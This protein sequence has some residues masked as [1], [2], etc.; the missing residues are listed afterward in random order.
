M[1][2]F[3]CANS[4]CSRTDPTGALAAEAP[5][6]FE[7]NSYGMSALCPVCRS[8]GLPDVWDDTDVVLALKRLR[9]FER[10]CDEPDAN[11][12]ALF[13]SQGPTL[14]KDFVRVLLKVNDDAR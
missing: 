8:H 5:T 4:R 10:A 6:V 9:I 11:F 12:M 2:Y 3:Y 14:L 1:I 13:I 7:L